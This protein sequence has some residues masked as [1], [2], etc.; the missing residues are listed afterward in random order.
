M[1]AGM[2]LED[3]QSD[4][5]MSLR[6]GFSFALNQQLYVPGLLYLTEQAH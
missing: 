3:L 2:A 5:T 6:E 1:L 4:A